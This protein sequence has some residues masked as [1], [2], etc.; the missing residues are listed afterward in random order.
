MSLGSLSRVGVQL[1]LCLGDR[2]VRVPWGGVS[3]RE[4]TTS[5]AQ[6]SLK[7]Q[8][9]KSVSEADHFDQYD[10]FDRRTRVASKIYLGATPLLPLPEET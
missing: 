9:V 4:L 7:T 6:F 1:M 2:V 3:P 5:Y 8:V 10:L